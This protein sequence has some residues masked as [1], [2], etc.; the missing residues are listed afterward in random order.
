MGNKKKIMDNK[1]LIGVIILLGGL[2]VLGIFGGVIYQQMNKK[3]EVVRVKLSDGENEIIVNENGEVTIITPFGTYKQTW[4]KE[5]LM[6]FLRSINDLDFNS[7][8]EFLGEGIAIEL[9]LGN[10]RVI[11]TVGDEKLQEIIEEFRKILE[12]VYDKENS[13]EEEVII[14]K[15][16]PDYYYEIPREEG[17]NDDGNDEAGESG[18][19]TISETGTSDPWSGSSVNVA[20]TIECKEVDP[21]TGKIVIISNTVCGK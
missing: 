4:D 3:S 1:N 9:T 2:L 21:K 18:G 16:N 11:I 13:E 20:K 7:L 6:K 19:G 5:K 17:N 12:D 8:S 14:K 10:G 15:S